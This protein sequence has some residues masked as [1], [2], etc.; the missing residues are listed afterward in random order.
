M[1]LP[2][3][4]IIGGC[5]IFPPT[6]FWNVRVDALPMHPMSAKWV[7]HIGA[8]NGLRYDPG[9]CTTTVSGKAV[10]WVNVVPNAVPP[11]SD[12]GMAP[13][14][15]NACSE[16]GDG[17]VLVIDTDTC[18]IYEMYAGAK[19]PDDSW[20]AES[21]AMWDLNSNAQRTGDSDLTSA[22]AA[23]LSVTA[24]LLMYD[25]ALNGTINHA[26]RFTTPVTLYGSYLWPATHYAS[27]SKDT[28]MPPMGARLRLRANF[29]VSKFSKINQ[30]ILQAIK[31]YGIVLADNGQA[32]GMQFHR[33][34][35][36]DDADLVNL[37][38]VL[39]AN[40]EAVDT[41]GLMV[42][43]NS[44]YAAAPT[45]A[46][47][48][49]SKDKLGRTSHDPLNVNGTGRP[50]FDL[51]AI[52]TITDNYTVAWSDNRSTLRYAGA[53]PITVTVPEVPAGFSLNITQE[54]TG[55]VA[56]V[57]SKAAVHHA[58]GA[59]HTAGQWTAVSLHCTAANSCLLLHG[60][61]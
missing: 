54:G 19:K 61:R 8:N 47:A 41:S 31:A 40:M 51:P 25:E 60:A 59:N 18:I 38:G 9:I 53:G 1:S 58:A 39:G 3:Q 49:V 10:K 22:D 26:I 36:W 12:F 35:R 20:T 30:H 11:Q 13:I 4:K 6:N 43:V 15:P 42:D 37:R 24:G 29:D 28:T 45:L 44:A 17:H 50:L 48:S 57:G 5:P 56:V 34:P 27:R 55:Q 14:P 52:K 16:P 2:G 46:V 7:N 21:T 23:G 32:W 33:D